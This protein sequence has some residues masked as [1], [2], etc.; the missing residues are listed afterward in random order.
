MTW[1]SI[2]WSRWLDE[3]GVIGA[4]IDLEATVALAQRAVALKGEYDKG[5]PQAALGLALALAPLPLQPD[6]EGAR[7]ALNRATAMAP[8][9]LT[10]I[11]DL[12]QYV[13]AVEGKDGEWRALLERVVQQEVPENDPDRLENLAAIQRGQ[14]LLLAGPDKRWDE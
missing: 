7:K 9:R 11:V 1:T 3:R 4:A 2:A 12:A 5:R 6:L 14:A 13:S 10:P 8:S